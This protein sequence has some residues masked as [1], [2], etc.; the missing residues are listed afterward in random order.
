V[1]VPG[2]GPDSYFTFLNVH[3]E[4]YEYG[5]ADHPMTIRYGFK[6]L[7]IE[8]PA[9]PVYAEWVWEWAVIGLIYES[10][11]TRDPYT[12]DWMPWLCKNYTVFTWV[13]PADGM[14]KSGVRFV[15]RDDVYWSD[16]TP[17][18]ASDV[19]WTLV[20]M[21]DELIKAGLPPPWWYSNV[22]FIK[23]MYMTDP[24]NIEILLDIKSV[25]AVGWIGG[26]II[27]PRHIWKPLLECYKTGKEYRPGYVPKDFEAAYVDPD[28]IACG[29]YRFVEYVAND[30]VLMV[31]NAPGSTVQ[32]AWTGSI[33]VTS[34]GYYRYY[35]VQASI[36]VVS[37]GVAY[38]HKMDKGAWTV[39]ATIENL[40]Q[41]E[42]ITA[43]LT[44]TY[45]KPD[46]TTTTN[47]YTVTVPATGKVSITLPTDF[48]IY[49][50]HTFTYT[51]DYN[52]LGR[53]WHYETKYPTVFW[54]TIAQDIGA[55]TLYDDIGLP[56]YPYKKVVTTPDFKVD[57]KD[58]GTAAK[59]FGSY[60]GHPRWWTLADLDHNYKV[61]MKDIGA[62]ARKFGWTA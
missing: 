26:C 7:S 1:N 24:Y 38:R 28:V 58:V 9:N 48:T 62:I 16:G 56:T 60:P 59:A 53:T 37:P 55:S 32:T 14:T 2:S 49:G 3:P 18:T 11:L 44:V 4:G 41:T 30:H 50:K 46:G 20:E 17:L 47:T 43:T 19:F 42:D 10:L 22:V 54:I 45:T 13:D 36:D 51:L 61:D 34:P 40:C 31:A 52:A 23:S 21:C 8:K 57:M 12:F 39:N 15:L 27:L 6:V 29:A 5:V 25:F 35:P 33:P